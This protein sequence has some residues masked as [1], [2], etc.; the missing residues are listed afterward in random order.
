LG[1]VAILWETGAPC[2]DFSAEHVN[3]LLTFALFLLPL[4]CCGAVLVAVGIL[5]NEGAT[6]FVT[7]THVY[8]LGM[9][10]GD[11]QESEH[12]AAHADREGVQE[13]PN[14][15]NHHANEDE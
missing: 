14:Y 8:S 15:E 5:R 7:L 4:T 1:A 6:D 3:F 12:Q 13:Q 11:C 2:S 10:C 9:H